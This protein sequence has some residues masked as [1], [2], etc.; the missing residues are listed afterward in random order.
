MLPQR[1]L[2]GVLHR[3]TWN[4]EKNLSSIQTILPKGWKTFWLATP[5]SCIL[6][7]SSVGG[8]VWNARWRSEPEAGGSNPPPRFSRVP[9]SGASR[10][11]FPTQFYESNMTVPAAPKIT[12]T[13]LEAARRQ[14]RVAI[15]LW[16]QNGDE[17]AIH[18]LACAAYQI[19]H[20]INRH[21][22]GEELFFDSLVI[23]EEYRD[24]A[25][26]RFKKEMNFFKHADKGSRR[27]G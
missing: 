15:S 3:K 27:S 12:I 13:K 1:L 24:Q 10:A 6:L 2:Y 9:G 11:F 17:V 21:R 16:F 18:T 26:K 22:G 19:I 7:V 25:I 14:L 8:V 20:D 4:V 23:R 5:G